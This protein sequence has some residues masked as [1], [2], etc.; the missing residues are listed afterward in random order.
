MAARPSIRRVLA[1]AVVVAGALALPVPVDPQEARAQEADACVADPLGPAVDWT[2]VAHGDVVQSNSESQGRI[3][4]GGDVTLTNFG[5]ASRFPV[6]GSRV[7]LAAGGDLSA[8]NVGVNN[9]A[10]P[11]AAPSRATRARPT[12]PS[13][14][15]AWTWT[16]TSR[17][18]D[19]APSPGGSWRR[20][21]W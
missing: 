4:A 14:A 12:G 13:R 15:G 11:T 6:D 20:T 19:A 16:P 2:I 21:A 5:V 8:T 1:L 18:R 9:G 17:R 10:S 7:D 3:A